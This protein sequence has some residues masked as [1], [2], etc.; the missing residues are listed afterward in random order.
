MTPDELVEKV[1]RAECRARAIVNECQDGACPVVCR[2]CE[3]SVRAAIATIAE[4]MRVPSDDM[5]IAGGGTLAGGIYDTPGSEYW[6]ANKCWRAMLAAS[7][8]GQEDKQ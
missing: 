4:A 7:P 5:T 8:L 1:A 3:A 2:W 6:G